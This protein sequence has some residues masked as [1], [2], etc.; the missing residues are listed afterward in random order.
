MSKGKDETIFIGGG[1]RSKDFERLNLIDHYLCFAFAG[2]SNVGKSS[3][4]NSLTRSKMARISAEPGKTREINFYL[5]NKCYLVD[6]PGYGYA[7]VSKD[8]RIEWGRDITEWIKKERRLRCLFILVDG[9]HSFQPLDE[10]L[11]L[12]CRK[13]NLPHVVL[14]TK[15]DK[16]KSKSQLTTAEHK[17]ANDC[18]RLNVNDYLFTSS[19]SEHGVKHLR[20]WIKE[21]L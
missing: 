17:L 8:K 4:L 15:M 2:R 11:V 12:F 14:F 21:G 13:N 16:Y 20:Q 19:H 5:W 18:N 6:L 1:L 3:L 7:K 10:D 9:R